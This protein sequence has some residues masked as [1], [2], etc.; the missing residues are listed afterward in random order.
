MPIESFQ[1]NATSLVDSNDKKVEDKLYLMRHFEK[2]L[3]PF[4]T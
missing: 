4:A 3:K 2:P 1:K